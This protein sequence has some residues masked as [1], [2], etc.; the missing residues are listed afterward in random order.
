MSFPNLKTYHKK[1]YAAID[2]S[3]PELDQ[4]GRT[5]VVTGGNSGIGFAIARSFITGGAAR[6][7]IIARRADKV[8]SAADE[9]AAEAKSKGKTTIVEGRVCDIS[10]S[11]ATEAFWAGLKADG[12]YV[13][14]LVLNAAA[15]GAHKPILES[16]IEN[17]W[18][19]F[20]ANVRS[21]LELTH[22]FYHQETQGTPKKKVLTNMMP[23]S[24]YYSPFLPPI[25]SMCVLTLE[26]ADNFVSPVPRQYFYMRFLHVDHHGG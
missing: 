7:I 11:D 9:L 5:V 21:S 23:S 1:P 6:V 16:S 3:R 22:R 8:K 26:S 12:I 19:D 24:A 2:P 4:T 20:N 15:F 14:V 25:Y 17:T 10:K 18:G 13:D